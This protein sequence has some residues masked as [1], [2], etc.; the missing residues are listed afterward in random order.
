[1]LVGSVVWGRLADAYGRKFAM[2]GSLAMSG[3]FGIIGAASAWY[4]MFLVFRFLSAV[5]VGGNVPLG[6]TVFT[7]VS[8]TNMRG[9][10]LTLLEAFW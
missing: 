6:F 2:I 10:Y 7:E 3:I 4:P 9:A 8:S 5:G 1:M